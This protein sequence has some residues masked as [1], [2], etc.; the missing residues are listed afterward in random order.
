MSIRSAVKS[1]LGSIDGISTRE[2][3]VVVF[4]CIIIVALNALIVA[5]SLGYG[6]GKVE[7]GYPRY[8]TGRHKRLFSWVHASKRAR[9]ERDKD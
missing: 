3:K 9:R 5:Y 8:F 2:F 4:C 1:G 7:C 6:Q